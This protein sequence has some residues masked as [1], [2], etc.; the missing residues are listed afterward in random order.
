MTFYENLFENSFFNAALADFEA[1]CGCSGAGDLG[2]DTEL[3]HQWPLDD[4]TSYTEEASEDTGQTAQ[5][6]IPHVK[7]A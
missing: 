5:Q 1:H 6:G 3:Q 2:V 7:E 4:A